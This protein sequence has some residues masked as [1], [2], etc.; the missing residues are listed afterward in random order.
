MARGFNTTQGVAITDRITTALTTHNTQRSWS[1]WGNLRANTNGYYWGKEYDH[2]SLKNNDAV[3]LV[4]S[5]YLS[6][7]D[8]YEWRYTR[9]TVG[10]WINV[11]VTYDQSTPTI[12][13]IVY[14]NGVVQTLQST[15]P[16]TGTAMESTEPVIIGNYTT[17]DLAF[18]GLLAEF[19]VWSQIL[20]PYEASGLGAAAFG[21]SGKSPA[22][23]PTGL[24]EYIPMNDSPVT[25][26]VLAAPTVTGTASQTHPT[27]DY[28]YYNAINYHRRNA[29]PRNAM[30]PVL[31]TGRRL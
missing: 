4:F 26:K 18:D 29:F 2:E 7:G 25:S 17:A 22:L 12:A 15:F 20:T 5:R 21:Y 24:V 14:F 16:M 23:Y 31:T 3:G 27:I 6:G 28:G 30:N 19:A 1:I 10:S 9:P 11:V 8:V 13:P